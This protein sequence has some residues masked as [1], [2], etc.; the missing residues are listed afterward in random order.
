ML[1][2]ISLEEI[3]S[4][5]IKDIIF[6]HFLENMI[7]LFTDGTFIH[8]ESSQSESEIR[9]EEFDSDNFYGVEKV[10]AAGIITPEEI[11]QIEKE[12]R[13]KRAE[14]LEENEKTHLE[15]L[16]AKYE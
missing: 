4:K 2:E 13:Q 6:S 7:L 14:E 15:R 5:T 16:K 10:I 9:P 3:K 8:F 1:K 11:K 12:E